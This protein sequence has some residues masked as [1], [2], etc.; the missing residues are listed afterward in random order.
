MTILKPGKK[1]FISFLF[2]ISISFNF[3]IIEKNIK[4]KTN[5]IRIANRF[6]FQLEVYTDN[7]LIKLSDLSETE[8][9]TLSKR[10][11]SFILNLIKNDKK[12][13]IFYFKLLFI[14][15]LNKR[16]G[17]LTFYSRDVITALNKQSNLIEFVVT[18]DYF[19]GKNVTIIPNFISIDTKYIIKYFHSFNTYLIT[20]TYLKKLN[21]LTKL[22]IIIIN[23]ITVIVPIV[24]SIP[25]TS[26]L[27]FNLF[28]PRGDLYNSSLIFI[29]SIFS[30]FIIYIILRRLSKIL[31]RNLLL[32]LKSTFTI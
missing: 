4:L 9:K 1:S 18:K 20:Q 16:K 22:I 28:S 8:L 12:N 19:I 25:S 14:L 6:I 5:I 10:Y 26:N 7:N 11:S 13:L 15:L 23:L 29:L 32:R 24:L 2:N 17:T 21:I 30:S 3:E 31:F 27:L